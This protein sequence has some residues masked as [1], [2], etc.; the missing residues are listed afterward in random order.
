MYNRGWPANMVHSTLYWRDNKPH[1]FLHQKKRKSNNQS[2]GDPD[3]N[4][5]Q[6]YFDKNKN[7][8][9]RTSGSD[10]QFPSIHKQH[11]RE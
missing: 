1:C 2:D 8:K 9:K 3:M 4:V 7:T 6:R 11:V 5:V 10:L